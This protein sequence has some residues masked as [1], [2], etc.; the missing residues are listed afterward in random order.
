M[1]KPAHGR[2]LLRVGGTNKGGPGRPPSEIRKVCREAFEERVPILM[3]MADDEE[4]EP[5]VRQKAIDML[6]RYGLG[7]TITPT[8]A[9]GETLMTEFTLALS[10][11]DD[12]G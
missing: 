8:G 4:L 9:E 6:G 10:A 11:N 1:R 12:A 7:T 5:T 2:G 3:A